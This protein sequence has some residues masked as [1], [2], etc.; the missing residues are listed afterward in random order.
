MSCSSEAISP[1]F[2]QMA[3]YAPLKSNNH[4]E[5]IRFD[6]YYYKLNTDSAEMK[7]QIT[8]IIFYEEGSVYLAKPLVLTDNNIK[9][10][11]KLFQNNLVSTL[12]LIVQ[13]NEFWGFY[14]SDHGKIL[15][16]T[17]AMVE[18]KQNYKIQTYLGEL[19][20]ESTITFTYFSSNYKG[21]SEGL[22]SKNI[23]KIFKFNEWKEMPDMVNPLKLKF[24]EYYNSPS[25]K[26]D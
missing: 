16:T 12:D 21:T 15:L 17:T 2:S 14:K 7:H 25:K 23:S 24:I 22:M 8:V 19:S 9:E 13:E 20:S 1:P 4:S 6:G 5:S 11:L 10:S 3:T 26:G 18:E